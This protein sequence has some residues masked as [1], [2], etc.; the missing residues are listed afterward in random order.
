MEVPLFFCESF[1]RVGIVEQN[2]SVDPLVITETFELHFG[3][4]FLK[5]E[6]ADGF[7]VDVTISFP[8]RGL[9]HQHFSI[10]LENNNFENEIAPA[11]TFCFEEE[12]AHLKSQGLIR[13]GSLD[14]A[15]VVGKNGV[16]NGPLRFE[17]EFVR[18]KTMDLLGD[19]TLLNRTIVGK[20]TVKKA[21]HRYHVELAKALDNKFGS[22]FQRVGENVNSKESWT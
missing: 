4:V 14:C 9:E 2:A 3:D 7:F 18:H 16:L 19:L 6:P 11:R 12:I 22:K 1:R 17:D 8:Y 5:A 20:I 15:L 21:G 10:K 13:G